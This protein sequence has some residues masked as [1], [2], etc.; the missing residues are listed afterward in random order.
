[1]VRLSEVLIHIGMRAPVCLF[2]P[3]IPEGEVFNVN[4]LP[5]YHRGKRKIRVK[6]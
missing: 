5:P 3:Q 4:S 6:P 1:M 2:A